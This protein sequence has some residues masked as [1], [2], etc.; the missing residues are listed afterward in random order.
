MLKKADS[1]H[2]SFTAIDDG[3]NDNKCSSSKQSSWSLTES[4]IEPQRYLKFGECRRCA[5][6]SSNSEIETAS[7]ELVSAWPPRGPEHVHI[8]GFAAAAY[9]AA[10]FDYNNSSD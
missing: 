5:I 2:M 6:V 9:E 1:D 8:M 3:I 7:P 4:E 10:R